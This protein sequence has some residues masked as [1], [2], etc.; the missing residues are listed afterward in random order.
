VPRFVILE[1]DHPFP[2]WD[3]MLEAEALL[4]TWR[5]AEFPAAGRVVAAEAGFDHR[6]VYLDYEGPVSSG[7]GT[8]RRTEQGSYETIADTADELILRLMGSRI[9]GVATLCRVT[10]EQ[11][12]FLLEDSA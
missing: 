10:G 9:N 6:P 8:V 7:R 3:F 12:R 2:H 5:L 1:H 4:R 11:W